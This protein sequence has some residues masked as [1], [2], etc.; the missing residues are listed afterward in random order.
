M[1]GIF[2]ID[3]P[4]ELNPRDYIT[5]SGPLYHE[6]HFDS[7]I[8]EPWN[9]ASSLFFLVPVIFWIWK[10]RGRYRRYPM[11]SLF[12]PLLFLNGIGSATYHA[13]RSSDLA[14]ML[15]W[16]PAFIMNLLLCWYMWNKVLRRPFISALMVAG[17]IT[18]AIFAI[19][20]FAPLIGGLAANLGYLMIGLCIL[21]PSAIFL[22]R[23]NFFKW[24]LL[25]G[26]FAI[27]A[28]ALLFRSLDYPTPNP[29][30]GLL[31]Q[32]THFLWHL[33]SALAVFT[34]GFYFKNVR[35]RELE[36]KTAYQSVRAGK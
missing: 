10:L 1:P 3:N 36:M 27:L 20:A 12:L 22:F 4:S 7:W 24:Q 25:I 14:L 17:F 21:I 2:N 30:P 26:T 32:G 35:D 23:S 11:I 6:F 19:I 8:H 9:A 13:F 28:L 15:D 16:M 31:P 34:L 33:T 29:F 5:D 18:A